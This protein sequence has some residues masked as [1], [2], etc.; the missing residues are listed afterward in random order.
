MRLQIQYEDQQRAARE[1][2]VTKQSAKLAEKPKAQSIPQ[3]KPVVKEKRV[4]MIA[5]AQAMLQF[6][7]DWPRE[8]PPLDEEGLAQRHRAHEI[9]FARKEKIFWTRS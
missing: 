5:R 6:Y 8:A 1:P 2:A 7:V 4:R 3:K 9:V